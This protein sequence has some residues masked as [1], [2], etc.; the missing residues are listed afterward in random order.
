MQR[1]IGAVCSAELMQVPIEPWPEQMVQLSKA[2]Q[3]LQRKVIKEMGRKSSKPEAAGMNWSAECSRSRAA[4]HT[5]L[6]SDHGD[7]LWCASAGC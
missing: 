6:V 2:F 7:N 1:A 5:S 3:S 4:S